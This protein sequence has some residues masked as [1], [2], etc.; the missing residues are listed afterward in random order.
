MRTGVLLGIEAH[1]AE[2]KSC[3]ERVI[4]T[5]HRAEQEGYGSIWIGETHYDPARPAPAPLV[6]AGALAA[7]TATIRLGV[8]VKI[9]LEHPLKVAEDSAVLDLLSNG[10]VLFGA[11]PGVDA[12]GGAS[13]RTAGTTQRSRFTEALDIIVNAWNAD[14]FAYRGQHHTLP[15]RTQA[16]GAGF[17]A[18]PFTPPYVEPWQRVD[19]PF[20][21]LSLLPKP[22]QLP[23]PPVFV[24]VGDH[25]T[26]VLAATMGYSP[27]IPAGTA[28]DRVCELA[29]S[30][31][32]S[33]ASCGRARAETV[34]SVVRNVCVHAADESP[35][36]LDPSVIAGTHRA[37]LERLKQL[38]HDT[39]LG[40]IVCRFDFPGVSRQQ[41]DDSLARFAAE[42]RPRL[43]M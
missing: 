28:P 14:G 27:L 3:F 8:L 23:H 15:R 42:V 43:E 11:D 37:V 20:D 35:P 21:Y 26:S 24:V 33:T 2:V 9:A 31:R 40:Q 29:S 7:E 39:G 34:L 32:R 12:A 16:S 1:E 22:A 4:T 6:F 17:L 5:A 18:E 10:R 38:Q 19:R 13:W 41:A 30:F 25:E 36:A